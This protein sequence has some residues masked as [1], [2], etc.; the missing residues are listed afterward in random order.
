MRMALEGVKVI[1]CS[2]VAAVPIAARH[3]GDFG[4][5]VIHVEHPVT[6]DFWRGFQEAQTEGGGGASP[7]DFNYNWEAFN[8]NKR[9]M[10]LN[11]YPIKRHYHFYPP[12]M[13]VIKQ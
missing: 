3:L 5:D 8:R 2:Q 4:A 1:D 12:F 9:S 10:T 6:G 7:S 13:D 11:L